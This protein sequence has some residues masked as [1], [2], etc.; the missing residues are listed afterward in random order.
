MKVEEITFKQI[1][2][3]IIMAVIIR[4][5][6][7]P[8]DLDQSSIYFHKKDNNYISNNMIISNKLHKYLIENK[9]VVSLKSDNL[10]SAQTYID[11]ILQLTPKTLLEVL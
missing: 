4:S 2:A 8:G 1:D 6:E 7:Y 5:G 9:L 11:C 3:S 10:F